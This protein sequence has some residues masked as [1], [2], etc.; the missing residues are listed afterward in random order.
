MFDCSMA[1]SM[2]INVLILWILEHFQLV[3]MHTKI[4]IFFVTIVMCSMFNVPC[5]MQCITFYILHFIIQEYHIIIFS[6]VVLLLLHSSRSSFS[7]CFSC[8]HLVARFT[9]YVALTDD[10]N[11]I[12]KSKWN[13]IESEKICSKN[14][15]QID[16]FIYEYICAMCSR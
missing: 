13:R 3:Q 14:P 15:Y 5:S 2:D 6:F 4:A 7:I 8:F 9:C 16:Y 10:E 1:L 11:R 12:N